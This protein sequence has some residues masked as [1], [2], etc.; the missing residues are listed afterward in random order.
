MN[1]HSNLRFSASDLDP[2]VSPGEDFYG[3]ANGGWCRAN[4]IPEDYSRWG[5]F[6]A[7][8][9][10]N[11]EQ[12][13]EI[14][15]EARDTP[16]APTGSPAQLVGDWYAAAMDEEAIER[17][18]WTPLQGL[19]DI[20]GSATNPVG[21]WS[22]MARLEQSGVNPFFEFGVQ[23][24]PEDSTRMIAMLYQGGLGLPEREY[25]LDP[26]PFYEQ[27][28][29]AYVRYLA[30]LLDLWRGA[31][32]AHIEEARDVLA[33]ER[34]LA[35]VSMTPAEQRD[36]RAIYHPRTVTALTT[37]IPEVHWDELF[38]GH[39]LAHEF[40]LNLAQPAFFA[41]VGS[42]IAETGPVRIQRYLALHL[43]SGFASYLSTPWVD[44]QFALTRALT[45]TE[46][47]QPRWLRVGRPLDSAIG[48]AL[49]QLYV[50]RY[51]PPASRVRAHAIFNAVRET[52]RDRV[53]SLAWMSEATRARALEKLDRLVT[54]IGYPD[55]WHD[56]TGLVIDRR[57]YVANVSRAQ[58]HALAYDLAKVGK[59]VD[60]EE[61]FMTPQTVNAYYHP[62][63]NEM[64]FP[65]G[66]LQPPFFDPDMPEA[67]NYGA[68]GAVIGHEMTHGFDDQG[69]KYDACGNLVDWW[70]PDDERRF[71]ERIEVLR[72]QLSRAR[73]KGDLTLNPDLLM[74][75]FIADIGGVNLAYEAMVRSGIDPEQISEVDGFTHGQLFFLAFA[76]L[77]AGDVRDDA[78]RLML[79]SDPHPPSTVRVN[80][81]LRNVPAFSR[82][83]SISHEA[84]LYP[85]RAVDLWG[86]R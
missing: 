12:L 55:C 34:E 20:I 63:R 10:K 66:I 75:E 65:A 3:Y 85:A 64:V 68:L 62:A 36:P 4:P 26:D 53:H 50:A 56:Y 8:D 48:F 15:E 46:R 52:F 42:L 32:R 54:R 77:W 2:T 14:L 82:A 43:L 22:L 13:R 80:E 31:D 25:Y 71:G 38:R 73:F 47:L 70:S 28:R 45:G 57:S 83:F 6:I 69:R 33:F 1:S 72:A 76:H 67:Y 18:G 51:F 29:E 24:D 41:R 19:L 79:A 74:G 16:D 44:A 40:P 60:P 78:L 27:A 9:R 21:L 17:A 23:Q 86:G 81:T 61:W 35:L 37:E 39:G 59:P 30:T 7:L 5:T 49:G 11:R 58:A 84:P